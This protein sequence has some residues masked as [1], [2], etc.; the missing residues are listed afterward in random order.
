MCPLHTPVWNIS[1][2][3]DWSSQRVP[4]PVWCSNNSKICNPPELSFISHPVAGLYTII[5]LTA[6]IDQTTVF[7]CYQTSRSFDNPDQLLLV[8]VGEERSCCLCVNVDWLSLVMDKTTGCA[9]LCQGTGGTLG[10][11]TMAG[12]HK[13]VLL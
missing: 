1:Y 11:H 2:L 10:A 12:R 5:N 4:G 9:I 3:K 7:K 13:S 6:I 8:E